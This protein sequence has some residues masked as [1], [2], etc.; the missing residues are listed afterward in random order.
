MA[1]KPLV[2]PKSI[3]LDKEITADNVGR[4]IL[5]PL[6]RGLGLT[7]GNAL[8]R[9]LLSSIQGAAI[10]R[11]RIDNVL[12]EFTTISGVY[13]DLTQII[14]N[15]KRIRVK[16]LTGGP[17]TLYLHVKEKKEYLCKT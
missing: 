3:E 2:M 15:L 10:T 11:V 1:L 5:S 6:E 9:M 16:L 12:Q 17:T 13:E 7:L 8:R 4:F 14:L